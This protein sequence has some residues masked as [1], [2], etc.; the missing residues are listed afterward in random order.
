L[1]LKYDEL[2]SSFAFKFNL[3]RYSQ[4]AGAGGGGGR[5]GGG[6]GRRGVAGVCGRV[7]REV[8]RC[9]LTLSNP[10]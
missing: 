1:N 10:S 3:R 5:G 6:G 8:R 9:M 7:L 2:R 4:D